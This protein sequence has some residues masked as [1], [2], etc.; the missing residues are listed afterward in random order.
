LRAR[1]FLGTVLAKH[2]LIPCVGLEL[3]FY[4]PGATIDIFNSI[5]I[6]PETGIDQYEIRFPPTSDILGLADHV[7]ATIAN[8]K[9][10]AQ[11]HGLAA[12][13]H[14]KPFVDQPGSGMHI[15]LNYLDSA[16]C[17][18]FASAHDRESLYLQ[19]AAGGLLE[20]MA[21]HM[22]LFAPHS[23]ARFENLTMETPTRICWGNNN[24][25][26]ALRVPE[27]QGNQAAKRLEHRVPCSD[28]DPHLVIGAILAGALYG[29]R[30]KVMPPP[31]VHGVA[32][33]EQ[34]GLPLLHHDN[35]ELSDVLLDTILA[36]S[37]D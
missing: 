24:R 8:I 20:W 36:I 37:A 7:V 9:A 5:D 31:K 16:G 18:L 25:T 33:D 23:R 19:H 4:L 27:V 29:V 32:F 14:S 35:A 28:S 21:R 22:A 17:N 13:F 30:N 3:E 6:A 2:D 10:L 11:Q 12:H 1:E 26:A 34:Y 15:H